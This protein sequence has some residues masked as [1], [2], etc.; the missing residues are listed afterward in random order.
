MRTLKFGRTA[1]IA[2]ALLF[3]LPLSATAMAESATPFAQLSGAWHGGGQVKYNDG[4][5]E[6]LSC[7]GNYSQKSAG[8]E[9]TL[10]IRCQS[11]SNKIDMK[12]SISYEGGRLSGHWSEKSFGLEGDVDG[13]SAAN[14]FTV[15]ISGQLQGSMTVSMNGANHS[16]S[17]A[18]TGPGFKAVSISFSRG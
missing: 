9:L 18:T 10:A 4:S 1:P 15:R 14:K 2:L 8:A 17:I 7:R 11:P 5:N 12:S 16:V 3:T 13:S 6:R